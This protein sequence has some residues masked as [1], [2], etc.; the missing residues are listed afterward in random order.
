MRYFVPVLRLS[1]ELSPQSAAQDKLGGRPWGLPAGRWPTCGDCG[2]SQS[3]LAQFLH[4]PVRLDLGRPGRL[5]SVFQCNHDP[6]LCATWDGRSGTNACFVSEP[7]ELLP[8]LS[9]LPE[10]WPPVDR[11]A[12]VVEWLQRDDG[13]APESASA[14]F[15]R[16]KF[17]DLPEEEAD[18]PTWSTRLGGVP[19]WLQHPELPPGEGWIFVGQLDS[20]Y[21]FLTP[22][23]DHSAGVIADPERWEGRSH[24]C[25]GP[26]LGDGGL[27]Y[28]FIRRTGAVPEGWFS[29][30]CT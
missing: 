21:S 10:D 17:S 3:L 16:S 5:L 7:E 24:Y 4:H 9:L 11:E 30:Q 26:N 18:R 12:R 29:W 22:P 2:R 23:S 15:A 19:R 14:F 20:T 6:G 25:E 28:L 8:S 13:L 1:E 27:A